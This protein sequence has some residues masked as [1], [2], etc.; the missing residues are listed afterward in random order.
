MSIKISE[1]DIF[2]F[3]FFPENVSTEIKKYLETSIDF[4]VEMEFYKSVN[5]SLTMDLSSEIKEKI[6]SKIDVYKTY[7]VINLFPAKEHRNNTNKVRL[8]AAS[9]DDKPKITSK[10]FYNDNMT[11]IIKVLNYENSSKIFVFSPQ[12]EVIKDFDL[13]ISPQNIKYHIDDNT[14]PLELDFNL[15]PDSIILEFNLTNR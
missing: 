14:T 5:N 11:Y 3:V 9:T 12:Y 4:E 1:R 6:A 2:N 13:I 15:D 7:T 8:A 10:T